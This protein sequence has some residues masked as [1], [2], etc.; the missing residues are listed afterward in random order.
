VKRYC[1]LLVGVA[2]LVAVA[3]C[4]G[5]A[6]APPKPPARAVEDVDRPTLPASPAPNAPQG[7]APAKEKSIEELLAQLDAIKAQQEQLEKARKET[8]ALVKEKLKEQ[9]QRLLKLG[10]E[11]EPPLTTTS[12]Y[13]VPL[14]STPR[15]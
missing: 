3:V 15:K 9:K 11:E 1:V 5:Q 2:L 12:S 6:P 4:V 7:A 8:V 13:S 10:V 14:P